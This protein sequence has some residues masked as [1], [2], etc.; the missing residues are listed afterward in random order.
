[1]RT[2]G[3]VGLSA[4]IFA[5]VSY[6]SIDGV[7]GFFGLRWESADVVRIAVRPTW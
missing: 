5:R 7:S 1:M 3:A 4:G 2:R 6:G